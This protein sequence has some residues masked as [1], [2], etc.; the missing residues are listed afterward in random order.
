MN[1][2]NLATFGLAAALAT[3]AFAQAVTFKVGAGRQTQQIAQVESVTDFETFTGRTDKVTG[4]LSF[5]PSKRTGSGRLVVD[6]A[7]IDTGIPLRNDHMRGPQW[8]NTDK[9]PN[10]IFETTSVRFVRGENYTVTGRFTMNGV[11]RNV[12]TTATVKHLKESAATKGAGFK[13][14]VLQVKTNFKVKLSDFGITI[15]GAATGKVANDVTISV[16]VYGQSG[17]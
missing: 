1:L 9:N 11:T 12:T 6:A 14:D 5:D 3:S 8:L 7:S 10:I 13:G 15:G 4:S 16:V 17:A 2:R